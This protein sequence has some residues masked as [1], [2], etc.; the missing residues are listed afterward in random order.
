MFDPFPVGHPDRIYFD[1]FSPLTRHVCK[2]SVR[3]KKLDCL[4]YFV[5][6]PM[7]SAYDIM[8]PTTSPSGYRLVKINLKQLRKFRLIKLAEK[9]KHSSEKYLLTDEGIFFLIKNTKLPHT[10]LLQDLIKNY[11]NSYIFQYLV[12]PYIKLETLC[13]P[14]MDLNIIGGLGRYLVSTFQKMDRSLPLVDNPDPSDRECHYWKYDKLE[15]YLRRKYHYDFVNL[16][17]SEEDWDEE[18]AYVRYFDMEDKSREVKVTFD[19]RS[20]KGYVYTADKEVKKHEI[21]LISDYLEKRT[22][23]P[24]ECKI[25]YFSSQPRAKEFISSIYCI[26]TSNDEIREII[27]N[28]KPFMNALKETKDQDDIDRVYEEIKSY[29][30]SSTSEELMK[31][32]KWVLEVQKNAIGSIH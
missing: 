29:P 30:D 7:S 14:K 12:Y 13:S 17:W 16:V 11:S 27:S 4:L 21:P 20:G 23:T 31:F 8:P 15:D 1:F 5:C 3:G 9:G 10:M 24:Y 22:R 26:N 32:G 6:H 25:R 19:R 28:D 2:K 18:H